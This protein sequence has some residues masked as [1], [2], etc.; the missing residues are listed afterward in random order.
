MG[1]LFPDMD[2]NVQDGFGVIF[3]SKISPVKQWVEYLYDTSILGHIATRFAT[4]LTSGKP[5]QF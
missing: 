4:I 1:R 2:Y 3:E 5:S